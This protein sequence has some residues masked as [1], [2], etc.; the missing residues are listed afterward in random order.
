MKNLHKFAKQFS[1]ASLAIVIAGV[2]M[3]ISHSFDQDFLVE[4]DRKQA[5]EKHVASIR[6]EKKAD[7]TGVALK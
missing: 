3:T 4:M 1:Y 5:I 2:T 7:D 6:A